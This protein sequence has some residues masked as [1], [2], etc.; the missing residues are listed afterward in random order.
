MKNT[1]ALFIL[2]LPLSLAG[3][4]SLS[5]EVVGCFGQDA[6]AGGGIMLSATAGET[7]VHTDSSLSTTL[8]QGF[9]QPHS[10]GALDFTIN[11]TDASCPAATDGA[12]EVSDITGCKPPYTVSWSTGD[13]GPLS[14]RLS[15][16]TYAVTV[17]SGLCSAVRNFTV[18]A[19]PEEDCVLRFFNAF[20]PNGDGVNDVWTVEN[21]TRPEFSD[22]HIEIFNRWGQSVWEG[23]GY[24]NRSRAWDGTG[25][26][27]QRLPDGTYFFL[28]EV[29]GVVY[30]GFIE[31]TK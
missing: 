3:Q 27:G 12:A 5:H 6:Q 30:K 15:P 24:D 8:T 19:G 23:R 14:E 11:I 21:I 20:S 25:R 2:L 10:T 31:L 4:V 18:G 22:N 16:G 13:S 9:H 29:A 7:I 26:R 1:A 28:A 17:T